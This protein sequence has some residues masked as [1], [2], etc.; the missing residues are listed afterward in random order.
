MFSSYMELATRKWRPSRPAKQ[1]MRRHLLPSDLR[2]RLTKLHEPGAC[3]LRMSLP[4]F[5]ETVMAKMKKLTGGRGVDV[6]FSSGYVSPT[7]AHECW[8]DIAPFGRFIDVG[9][10]NVHKRSALEV[11]PTNRGA[12]YGI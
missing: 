6:V 10:K 7:V 11:L 12:S 8:R 5:D 1:L 2:P 4:F 3:R 9:R